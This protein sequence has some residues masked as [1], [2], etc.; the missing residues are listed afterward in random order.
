MKEQSC[1]LMTLIV[2]LKEQQVNK[3]VSLL[4]LN[5][6]HFIAKLNLEGNN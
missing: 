1:K 4:S 3:T 2:F 6:A 5:V